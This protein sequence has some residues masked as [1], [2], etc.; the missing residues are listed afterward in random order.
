MREEQAPTACGGGARYSGAR[1]KFG[2]CFRLLT[3]RQI[4]IETLIETL[5]VPLADVHHRYGC[6]I[7]CAAPTALPLAVA[8]THASSGVPFTF[9]L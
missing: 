7:R 5:S 4:A 1:R 6:I 3:V 8:R 9:V 2:G